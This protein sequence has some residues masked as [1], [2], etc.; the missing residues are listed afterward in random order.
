MRPLEDRFWAKVKKT[1]DCWLWTASTFT[2]GYG[3]FALPTK[4]CGR[5]GKNALAHRMAYELLVGP[6]AAG[7]ELDHTCEVNRCVNPAHLEPVAHRVNQLRT[8]GL[9]QFNSLKTVCIHGHALSGTNVRMNPRGDRVCKAC[10]AARAR[11]YR[12]RAAA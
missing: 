12:K 11:A 5:R 10:D 7:L 9:A 1:D 3:Q 4:L 6:I 8:A 2:N